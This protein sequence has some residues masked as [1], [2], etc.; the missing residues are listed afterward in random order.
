MSDHLVPRRSTPARHA[1]RM[2][3]LA[4]VAAAAF[5]LLATWLGL[6]YLHVISSDTS[7]RAELPT[8]GDTLGPGSDVK[9]RGLIVGSVQSLHH[10]DGSKSADLLI[11]PE[12]SRQ[13]PATVRARVLP[14][15]LFGAEYVELVENG[16]DTATALSEG[17]LVGADTSTE[18]VRLMDAF[19]AVERI[20]T[21]LD[22][23][24][25]DAALSNL[26]RA[27]DGHGDDLHRFIRRADRFVGVMA[28]H[29]DTFYEDLDLLDQT[30]RT[31]SAVE[32]ELVAALRDSVTTARTVVAR[33]DDI[34]ELVGGS[35]ALAARSRALLDREG[36][37]MI[38]LLGATGPTLDAFAHDTGSLEDLITAAP[39][40]LHNG[41]T[42]VHG[43]R[44]MM[45]GLIGT[46]PLDPYTSADCPRYGYA[47]GS[48]CP[49][50]DGR[51][52]A[53]RPPRSA[54]EG[55]RAAAPVFGGRSG[56][57]GSA[58]EKRVVA[59]V[60]Q[61]PAGAPGLRDVYTLLAA[62]VLRGQ[63]VAR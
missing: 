5:G 4:A 13:I 3:T 46:N 34:A 9:Y 49:G 28:A 57:V 27:L 55:G 53:Y 19:D 10:G 40:V 58:Q 17:D 62:P 12:Q 1:F 39:S 11:D 30:L 61:I 41:A 7:V 38:R 32:P 37:R 23:A 16:R 35:T 36:D 25:V 54:S 56:P 48:N 15:T 31:G 45:E 42:S 63:A 24:Q 50:S 29:E 60:F 59:Q 44:I 2:L 8:L 33:Q 21:A 51:Y 6:S 43:Q 47:E 14:G 20:L 52:T 26:A 22:P 18:T